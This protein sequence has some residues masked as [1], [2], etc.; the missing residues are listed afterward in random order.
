VSVIIF[1]TRKDSPQRNVHK[2]NSDVI[3]S[4]TMSSSKRKNLNTTCCNIHIQC[5][6]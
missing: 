5:I 6:I 2:E 3:E 4:K 1:K